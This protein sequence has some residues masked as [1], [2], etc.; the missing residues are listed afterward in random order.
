[1]NECVILY[2]EISGVAHE[3]YNITLETATSLSGPF[4]GVGMDL[5]NIQ[6][7]TVRTKL[8]SASSIGSSSADRIN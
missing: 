3:H 6:F 7:F 5:E 8:P 4:S 1:M 2:G